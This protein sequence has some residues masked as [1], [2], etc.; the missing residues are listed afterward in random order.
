MSFAKNNG[1]YLQSDYYYKT[2]QE[3]SLACQTS[4]STNK[5]Y[6]S[7][8]VSKV[9][10]FQS[11]ATIQNIV[12]YQPVAVLLSANDCFIYFKTGV[13]REKDC[14][15]AMTDS[16]NQ[17]SVNHAGVIVGF[18]SSTQY[19]GCSGYW[20]VKNSWDVNWAESGY[21]KLCIRTSSSV[22]TCNV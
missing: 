11:V 5:K 9:M 6:M 2:Y 3:K 1:Y 18:A 16:Y 21:I 17:V 7:T 4:R 10:T 12:Q 22:G 14:P 8:M 19:A 20:I 15:C 13:L